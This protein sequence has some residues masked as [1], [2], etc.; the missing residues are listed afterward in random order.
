M[1]RTEVTIVGAGMIGLTLANRLAQAGIR[2]HLIEKNKPNVD[3][4]NSVDPVRVSAITLKSR[5]L[6]KSVC[7]WDLLTTQH[8]TPF[9]KI[10][11]WIQAT[12]ADIHFDSQD[13]GKKQLGFIVHNAAL[14]QAL[15]GLAEKNSLIDIASELPPQVQNLM[16]GADG[17]RSEVREKF[18]FDYVERS[19]GQRAI[20]ATVHTENPHHNTAYQ[21]FL[22]TGPLGILPLHD[23]HRMSIVWSA[24]D[25]EADKLMALS[26]A[27]FDRA[28]SNA[29]SM[30]LG[31]ISLISMRT[32]FP[33]TMRHAKNYVKE[34][35]VLIG[36]AAHTIHPLAGQ[37]A[38]LGFY[39]VRV[40]SQVLIDAFSKGKDLKALSVLR[41]YERECK[42]K[43]TAML[44]AMQAFRSLFCHECS[45]LITALSWGFGFFN[46]SHF[47][48]KR[49]LL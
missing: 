22:N 12:G 2:V 28:L 7:A 48:K 9:S 20:V 26:E 39:E 38:N 10:S 36:D 37:G 34:G 43:N 25:N 47:F 42:F 8:V 3:V 1:S 14:I 49:M 16:I 11:A 44:Y 33:L 23:P 45:V 41:S 15:W 31:K 40:L 32:Q 24:D 13:T 35:V 18:E 4:E 29:L 19:Y 27:E 46:Q 5:D 17:G 21:S 30:K 6:L